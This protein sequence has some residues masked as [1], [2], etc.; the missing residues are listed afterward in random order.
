MVNFSI[1]YLIDNIKIFVPYYCQ[2]YYKQRDQS[3]EDSPGE[4]IFLSQEIAA[5]LGD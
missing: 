2:N 3:K 5:I 1:Q 4:A